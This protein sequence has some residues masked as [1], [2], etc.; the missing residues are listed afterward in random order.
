MRG[1]IT[2]GL[3]LLA[4]TP[5]KPQAGSLDTGFSD[6]GSL[7]WN[8][9]AWY[10]QVNAVEVLIDG[11]AVGA[12]WMGDG[13]YAAIIVQR[14]LPNGQPDLAFGV[15]GVVITAAASALHYAYGIGLQ[16]TGK[17]VVAG[18]SY[19]GS[20]DGDVVLLRYTTEGV[21]DTTF[22]DEGRVLSDLG[23][24]PGFQAAYALEVMPDDR[25]LVVGQEDENGIASARFSAEGVLDADYGMGGVAVSG[26]PA[27]TGLCMHVY[28]DGTVLAGG[29]SLPGGDPAW[30]LVRFDA[31][32]TLDP[33]FGTGGIA[34]HDVGGPTV[35][36]MSGVAVLSDGSIAACGHRS[37]N[38]GD[39]KPVIALFH[40][41]GAPVTGFG[42]QGLVVVPYA[43]PQWARATAIQ[44]AS[45]DKLLVAGFRVQPG[46]EVNN[47]FLLL[48]LH[49]NGAYDAAFGGGAPVYTDVSGSYDRAHAMALAPDGEIVLAGQGHDAES[50]TAYARYLND[51]NTSIDAQSKGAAELVLQP[52]PATDHVF[53]NLPPEMEAVTMVS[54]I[55]M[56]G[57]R[58]QVSPVRSDRPGAQQLRLELPRSITGLYVV[59]VGD[60]DVRSHARLFVVR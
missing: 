35:E 8:V 60:G 9:N 15:G 59:E 31:N 19:D 29:Y 44:V 24:G 6:D 48:R 2:Y 4:I 43:A 13:N 14:L 28:A 12:G 56:D 18:L 46:G 41:D 34:V 27:S 39:D 23:G 33:F 5:A 40:A 42:D 16:S 45:D 10:D 7:V 1:L 3:L 25:I 22:G 57:R 11:R 26:V 21:L 51:L 37:A 54:L 36:S 50:T 17:V 38:G 47:D 58:V 52:N 30:T 20:G 53:I 55:G 49:S 32:G